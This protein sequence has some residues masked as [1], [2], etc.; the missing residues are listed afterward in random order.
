M[1]P[2]QKWL[3]GITDEIRV[4]ANPAEL[5]FIIGRPEQ[6][7]LTHKGTMSLTYPTA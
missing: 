3:T 1:S 6:R 4:P 5:D 7:T 2:S